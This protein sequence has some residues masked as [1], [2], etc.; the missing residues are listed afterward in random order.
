VHFYVQPVSQLHVEHALVICCVAMGVL[1]CQVCHTVGG[2]VQKHQDALR[3][4]TQHILTRVTKCTD[5]DGGIIENV[6]H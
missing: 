5:V 6:L 1:R 4:A 3:R 2:H